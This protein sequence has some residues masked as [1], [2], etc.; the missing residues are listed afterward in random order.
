[1]SR[2]S[3]PWHRSRTSAASRQQAVR[4]PRARTAPPQ[5]ELL[6]SRVALSLAGPA[7]ALM[8]VAPAA[9]PAAFAHRAAGALALLDSGQA[10]HAAGAFV[11][12]RGD[13]ETVPAS[14]PTVTSTNPLVF[15]QSRALT[16]HA[17]HIGDIKGTVTVTCNMAAGT[18]TTSFT[19]ETSRGDTI[20]GTGTGWL[21]P[22][23]TPG[24][25]AY[26][27]INTISGGTGRFAGAVG[28]IVCQGQ[29]NMSTGVEAGKLAG[30]ILLAPGHDHQGVS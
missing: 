3:W 10:A 11:L 23:A 8:H 9:P 17:S 15:V 21:T 24:V 16:G 2:I 12:L 7:Q 25:F 26:T 28:A 22:T 13:L 4:S 14:P 30:A 5:V 29:L 6:E 19:L 27:E 20:T 1:M 18:Y